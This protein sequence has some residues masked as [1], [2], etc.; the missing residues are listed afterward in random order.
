MQGYEWPG[1]LFTKETGKD[2]DH[3]ALGCSEQISV[4]VLS[5]RDRAVGSPG[6]PAL[7][8]PLETQ[9]VR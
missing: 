4:P 5:D 8:E 3:V 6:F 7:V 2:G 1:F 9:L